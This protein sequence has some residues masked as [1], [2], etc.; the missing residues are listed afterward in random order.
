MLTT[1]HEKQVSLYAKLAHN[2]SLGNMESDG[3]HCHESPITAVFGLLFAEPE[4]AP[5]ILAGEL[6]SSGM[7][8]TMHSDF[9]RTA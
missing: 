1:V 6:K 2:S 7:V 5:T 9:A 8:P 3:S 4:A